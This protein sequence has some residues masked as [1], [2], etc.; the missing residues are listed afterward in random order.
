MRQRR[1]SILTGLCTLA[2][3]LALAPAALAVDKIVP[4]LAADKAV[5]VQECDRLAARENDLAAV[6]P[7]VPM[8]LLN[9]ATAML[10]CAQSLNSYPADPR[11]A[12][13]FGRALLKAGRVDE[14]FRYIQKAAQANYAAA[15]AALATLY[16]EGIGTGI[17]LDQAQL[18]ARKSAEAGDAGGENNLASLYERGLGLP[19]DYAEAAR[20][21]RKAAEQ[22]HAAAQ[23]NL[24][25][26]YERDLVQ[27][28]NSTAQSSTTQ[29]STAQN[30][31][32]AKSWYA[33]AA[34][35]HFPGAADKL[36]ELSGEK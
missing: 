10:A 25:S 20:W 26:L 16:V 33:K 12:F 31:A 15:A 4:A 28:Q 1:L 8:A 13:Q 7:G 18:W 27:P 23:Y 17:N 3:G 19:Q 36:K 34:A 14:A 30:L 9:P 11:F 6:A 29:S 5:P 2:M 24:A 22:S 32:L 21:Y 35:A